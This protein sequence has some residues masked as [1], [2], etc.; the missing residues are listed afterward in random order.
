M[1]FF[2]FVL[3]TLFAVAEAFL[4]R[5]Y[6]VASRSG[7]LHMQITDSRSGWL[8]PHEPMLPDWATVFSNLSIPDMNAPRCMSPLKHLSHVP[9]N[10][11]IEPMLT[12]VKKIMVDSPGRSKDV[13][14]I[15]RGTGTGT[16]TGKTT[17]LEW[18][19]R[20]MRLRDKATL[21]LAITFNHVSPSAQDIES[22]AFASKSNWQFIYTMA[23]IARMAGAYFDTTFSAIVMI[24][25]GNAQVYR[26]MTEDQLDMPRAQSMLNSFISFLLMNSNKHRLFLA[27]DEVM[28]SEER[29]V[30]AFPLTA[31]QLQQGTVTH[32]ALQIV[33]HVLLNKQPNAALL[34]SSLERLVQTDS[35]RTVAPLPVPH[36]LNSSTLVELVDALLTHTITIA[37]RQI[38]YL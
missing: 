2:L 6:P 12:A 30:R 33:R 13:L 8:L 19:V 14:A 31:A 26:A 18:L 9:V 35:D 34:V 21:S 15:Y 24:L 5:R 27:V 38:V 28:N 17:T 22:L 10:L 37:A 36:R 32:D 23:V 11:D 25:R 1:T 16:G 20:E 29:L 7:S 4:M 3:A